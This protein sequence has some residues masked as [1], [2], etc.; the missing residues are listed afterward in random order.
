MLHLAELNFGELKS[1]HF[2]FLP[3]C[4]LLAP[5]KPGTLEALLLLLSPNWSIREEVCFCKEPKGK[6]SV[7]IINVP[8][9]LFLALVVIVPAFE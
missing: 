6:T 8:N 5:K 4:A 3:R 9:T 2:T 7:Q 1:V